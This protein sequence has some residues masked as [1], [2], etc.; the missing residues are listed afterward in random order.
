M[1]SK[2]LVALRQEGPELTGKGPWSLRVLAV[3]V[4]SSCSSFLDTQ[5]IL[6]ELSSHSTAE[7]RSGSGPRT[8]A[9]R[10]SSE[11][12]GSNAERKFHCTS[13]CDQLSLFLSSNESAQTE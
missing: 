8:A 1:I 4:S 12:D 10:C 7:D 13:L 2:H 5:C 9:A 6:G 11:E 3:S